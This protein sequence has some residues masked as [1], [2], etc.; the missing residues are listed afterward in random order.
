MSNQYSDLSVNSCNTNT[1][2]VISNL[3]QSA[4]CSNDLSYE[5]LE[6]DYAQFRKRQRLDND[7]F[8]GGTDDKQLEPSRIPSFRN[9][10]SLLSASANRRTEEDE[11]SID[12]MLL[13]RVNF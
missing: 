11:I 13:E 5:D 10:R 12:D 2:D 3:D 1:I 6:I 9:E 7:F 8:L 4:P